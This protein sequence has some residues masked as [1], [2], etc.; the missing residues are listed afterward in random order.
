MQ[1]NQEKPLVVITG[2]T[3]FVGAH[4]AY[5]FLKDGRFRVRGTVRDLGDSIKLNPVRKAF[6][7]DLFK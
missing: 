2:I 5:V 6:G 1:S 7:E 4:V 3:G